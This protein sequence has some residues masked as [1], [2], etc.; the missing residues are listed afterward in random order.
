MKVESIHLPSIV[1]PCLGLPD[2]VFDYVSAIMPMFNVDL[3]VYKSEDEFILTRR[4]NDH[5][6]PGWHV[7]GSILRLKS[8]CRKAVQTKGK[9]IV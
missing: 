7:P 1:D 3:L 8:H 5:F 4:K 9:R 6:S 2:K